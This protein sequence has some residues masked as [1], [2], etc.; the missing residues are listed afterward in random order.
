MGGRC[1]VDKTAT[2]WTFATLFHHVDERLNALNAKIDERDRLYSDLRSADKDAIETAFQAQKE[3]IA[4]ALASADRAVAKSESAND[5]RFDG[6]N[7]FRSS[8]SDAAS[9]MMP[10]TET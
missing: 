6:V 1:D 5:K 4:A 10:R 2:D 7:E 3:A 9:R 8:L